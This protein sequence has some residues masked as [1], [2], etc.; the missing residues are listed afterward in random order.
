[1]IITGAT[2]AL[3]R[4]MVREFAAAGYFIG[5]GFRGE[6][7]GAEGVL[8]DIRGAGADGILLEGDLLAR[9][10]AA[11]VVERFLAASPVL[12][13]LVNNAGGNR[14]GLF[15]FSGE[16]DWR[17]AIE[18]N[19]ITAM[20][21][22]RAVLPEM[23]NRRAGSIVNISSISGVAGRKGQTAYGAAKA[24]LN[25]FTRA[26]AREVGRMNIRV[27]AIAAGAIESPATAGLKPEEMAWLEGVASLGRLGRP[28]EVAAVARF[29]ASG[30]ASFIT[31]QI[32]NVDGGVG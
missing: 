28:E 17:A 3:G 24:G 4:Q 10:G 30:A 27:N 8:E 19:L 7:A 25:G 12:D 22:S 20:S 5:I 1:M 18:E 31:G 23:I 16:D 26:L 21:M 14:D 9:G 15:Y 32:I 13:A 6:P 2:G 29:L 11:S